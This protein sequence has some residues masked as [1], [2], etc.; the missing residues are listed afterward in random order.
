MFYL[1][2]RKNGCCMFGV[3]APAKCEGCAFS[4]L[5]G[6]GYTCGICRVQADAGKVLLPVTVGLCGHSARAEE[7]NLTRLASLQTW[8][9]RCVLSV[10]PAS[11][12]MPAAGR[13]ILC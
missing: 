9:M 13:S 6:V 11:Y 5:P 2:K 1:L 3:Y 4:V 8:A 10:L 12:G 7:L